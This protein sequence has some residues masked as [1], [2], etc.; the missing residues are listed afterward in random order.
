MQGPHSNG[1][2]NQIDIPDGT[3]I[4]RAPHKME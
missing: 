2:I 4:Y 1:I 3:S